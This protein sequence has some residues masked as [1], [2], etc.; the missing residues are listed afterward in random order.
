MVLLKSCIHNVY[1][2]CKK[3]NSINGHY[4]SNVN[5]RCYKDNCLGSK[6]SKALTYKKMKE[7][8]ENKI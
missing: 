4:H 7:I 1:G 3:C 5:R 2:Y 6:K 8:Y